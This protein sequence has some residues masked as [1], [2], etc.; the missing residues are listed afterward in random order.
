MQN[1][2][3][4]TTLL[5]YLSSASRFTNS[6]FAFCI[7]CARRSKPS[8][9]CRLHKSARNLQDS[10]PH[11]SDPHPTHSTILKPGE[12]KLRTPELKH[13]RYRDG[14]LVPKPLNRP[15]GLNYPPQ[16]GQNTG[17]DLRTWRQKRDDYANYEGYLK[18]RR[19]MCVSSTQCLLVS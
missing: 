16:P 19:Q 2:F 8:L 14:E 7:S 10:A 12:R 6:T 1:S 18:R 5:R 3:P 13:L 17:R 9:H 15:L 4:S 11:S